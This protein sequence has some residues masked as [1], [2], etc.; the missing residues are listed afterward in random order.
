MSLALIGV[1]L[2]ALA[3]LG[4]PLF[5]IIGALALA[6]FTS[7]GIDTQAVIIELYRLAQSPFMITIPLFTFAGY[8]MAEAKTATRIVRLARAGMGWLPG[9]LALVVLLTCAFFTTFTGASGV[10]II[11]LGGLL[12]PA[13]RAEKYPEDFSFGLVTASGSMGL[14]FPPSLP[15]IIYGLVANVEIDKLFIAGLLPGMVS[16]VVL[17]G[18]GMW[19]AKRSGIERMPV[20]AREFVAAL[21]EAKWELAVPVLIVVGI[22]GG[23]VTVAEAAAITAA[24]VLIIEVFV[25]K[26]LD[27]RKDVPRVIQQS[28][29]L[30][31][32]IL[33]ILGVALGL[34]NYL[35]DAQVP[36]KIFELIKAYLTSKWAFLLAL[37]LFLLVVGCLLDIFSAIIVVV[38]L[39]TP[40]AREVG[41][42][43]IH[44]GIIFL[45]NLQ[46]G[47][48][49]PPVGMN[50]FIAS[51]AF[52][53]PM[54]KVYKMALPYLLLLLLALVVITYVPELSLLLVD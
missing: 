54:V 39:I 23:F 26:D 48:L 32:A 29:L 22:Y 38:P 24:Y 12:L 25:Y 37:N 10:T 8:L 30:V 2:V 45:A 4:E 46:I 15:I 47:Y 21:G 1:I 19:V 18:Y 13:L 7:E 53:Q 33:V 40:V 52:D 20:D 27:L 28:M 11:A 50:L 34:T 16:M 36:E 6:A 35:V 3:L 44:L 49:T 51:L 43:P 9:G 31:G 41:V 42:D 5:V 14:L 17:G